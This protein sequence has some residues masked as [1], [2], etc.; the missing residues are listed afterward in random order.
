MIDRTTDMIEKARINTP[1]NKPYRGRPVGSFLF[2]LPDACLW[3][4]A[5]D[6]NEADYLRDGIHGP[7][8]EHVSVSLH[9]QNHQ[10]WRRLPTWEEMCFIKRL[11]WKPDE[12][13]VQ[14]H[15]AEAEYVNENPYTLHLWRL[16]G[17]DF[18]LP[19]RVLV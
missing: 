6:G 18:P 9:H 17:T 3:V 4:I 5:H 8:W 19:P 13:V 15:P 7:R 1:E 14:F 16:V 12:T 2:R 10:A 11:F